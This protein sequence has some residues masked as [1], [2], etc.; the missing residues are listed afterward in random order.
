MYDLT[1]GARP[2]EI[3][4]VQ[5]AQPT[6][7]TTGWGPWRKTTWNNLLNPDGSDGSFTSCWLWKFQC[8]YGT[9]KCDGSRTIMLNTGQLG[10][11]TPG[12]I[13][14]TTPSE[15]KAFR[16]RVKG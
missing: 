14:T 8:Y 3:F 5:I 9:T 6:P 1:K 10:D 15:L 13:M 11:Q 12:Y 2:D 16:W 7:W 4:H